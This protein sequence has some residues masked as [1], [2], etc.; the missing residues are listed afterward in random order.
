MEVGNLKISRSRRR[1]RK[2][3]RSVY[4]SQLTRLLSFS[5]PLQD[6]LNT[7]GSYGTLPPDRA[8]ELGTDV[9][10]YLTTSNKSLTVSILS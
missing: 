7:F 8:A 2:W 10:Y 1:K 3:L 4:G 9:G 6:W 5:F